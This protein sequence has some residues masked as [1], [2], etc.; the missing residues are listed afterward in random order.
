[1]C[2]A[3]EQRMRRNAK[4]M[5]GEFGMKNEIYDQR[6]SLTKMKKKR[7]NQ[8][9][10]NKN[11]I[12]WGNHYANRRWLLE[13]MCKVRLDVIDFKLIAHSKCESDCSPINMKMSHRLIIDSCRFYVSLWQRFVKNAAPLT[14]LHLSVGIFL[15]RRFY[16]LAK[17]KIH[18]CDFRSILC[19]DRFSDNISKATHWLSHILAIVRWAIGKCFFF[20]NLGINF[21][22]CA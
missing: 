18:H 16:S 6:I 14:R 21:I 7:T 3:D 22:K 15:V 1:M 12:K 11:L 19:F 13:V 20:W 10:W 4:P 8:M 9:K 2:G 17:Y 5:K